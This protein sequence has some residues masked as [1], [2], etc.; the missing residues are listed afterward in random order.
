MSLHF[1]VD[2]VVARS[3]CAFYSI[4]GSPLLPYAVPC[5]ATFLQRWNAGTLL[6]DP[7]GHFLGFACV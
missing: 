1:A 2:H 6:V 7:L 5:C 3:E 4:A